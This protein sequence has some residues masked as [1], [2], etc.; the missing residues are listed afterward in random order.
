MCIHKEKNKTQ[1]NEMLHRVIYTL[2]SIDQGQETVA[3]TYCVDSLLNLAVQVCWHINTHQYD[4][5][6][7]S[8]NSVKFQNT[9]NEVYFMHEHK[10][11]NYI[12][13]I[14]FT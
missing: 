14:Q 7:I 3:I 8:L 1:K 5:K 9:Y 12:L 6:F 13:N 10:R 11:I 2:D 4:S